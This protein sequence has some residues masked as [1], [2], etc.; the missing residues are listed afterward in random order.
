LKKSEV[1]PKER[2][3]LRFFYASAE[4]GRCRGKSSDSPPDVVAQLIGQI[5]EKDVLEM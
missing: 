3:G 4:S 1:I 2:R 5:Y